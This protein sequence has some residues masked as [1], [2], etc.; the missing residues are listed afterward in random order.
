M[1]VSRCPCPACCAPS[2]IIRK[3]FANLIKFNYTW[4]EA[5]RLGARDVNP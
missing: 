5:K 1:L 4:E 2:G 3:V